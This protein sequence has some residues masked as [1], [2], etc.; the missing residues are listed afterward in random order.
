TYDPSKWR[1]YN[2][3]VSKS[4]SNFSFIMDNDGVSITNGILSMQRG[5]W[6]KIL[7]DPTNGI[8]IQKNTGTAGSPTWSD[9]FYADASGNLILTGTIYANAGN[10][11]GWNINS[12]YLLNGATSSY[13]VGMSS[14]VSAGD[15]SFW[16]GS[17]YA[18]RA[19]APFR[20]TNNG[21]LYATNGMFT[22]VVNATSGNITGKL[23]FGGNSNFYIDGSS[24]APYRI[25]MYG[26]NDSSFIVDNYGNVSA[27]GFF[28]DNMSANKITITPYIGSP[29]PLGYL[30]K[31]NDLDGLTLSTNVNTDLN[32]VANRVLRIRNNAAYGT[33]LIGDN[34]I[35]KT[36]IIGTTGGNTEIRMYGRI[37]MNGILSSE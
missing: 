18:N 34:N 1:K 30:H 14:S 11:G 24:G 7:L 20:V 32:L 13:I 16:A 28:S 33:I 31:A 26:S 35:A 23:L 21:S 17:T 5:S 12:N 4:G 27:N 25:Y 22:G 9:Q 6:S 10:I 2:T 19:S 8:K 3:N 15:I 36:I 37:F 29:Y